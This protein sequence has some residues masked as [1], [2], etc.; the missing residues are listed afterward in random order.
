MAFFSLVCLCVGS[1][2]N[3]YSTTMSGLPQ[4]VAHSGGFLSH[5]GFGF[6]LVLGYIIILLCRYIILMYYGR[7]KIEMLDIL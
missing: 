4:Y 6:Y 2:V 3:N 7:I 5:G 1:W